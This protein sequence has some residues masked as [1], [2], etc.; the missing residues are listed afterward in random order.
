[1]TTTSEF[2]LEQARVAWFSEHLIPTNQPCL[3][4]NIRQA[5]AI[6]SADG[7]KLAPSDTIP[8]SALL[9][10]CEAIGLRVSRANCGQEAVWARLPPELACTAV[11]I[12]ALER[13]RGWALTTSDCKLF[14]RQSLE[15]LGY[16]TTLTVPEIKRLLV[17]QPALKPVE[18]VLREQQFSAFT[19]EET[20]ALRT[21]SV[22]EQHLSALLASL[23][24]EN[25]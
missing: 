20:I 2:L 15:R 12:E 19:P 25:S 13:R 18:T 4:R 6:L 11:A 14:I 17:L 16:K 24:G 9:N 7:E 10:A 3:L 1:M 23:T 22:R 8:I 21:V 5:C